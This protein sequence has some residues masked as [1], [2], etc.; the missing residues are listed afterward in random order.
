MLFRASQIHFDMVEGEIRGWVFL[1]G[2]TTPHPTKPFG[3][4]RQTISC[5]VSNRQSFHC[6]AKSDKW[7]YQME[8]FRIL[9]SEVPLQGICVRFSHT[10]RGLSFMLPIDMMEC[11]HVSSPSLKNTIQPKSSLVSEIIGR[12]KKKMS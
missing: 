4:S 9:N 8:K 3:N 2:T 7:N 1:R 10:R 11:S 5:P 6:C 12:L